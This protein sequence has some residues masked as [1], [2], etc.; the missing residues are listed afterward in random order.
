M[1]LERLNRK[2]LVSEESK[3]YYIRQRKLN[4]WRAGKL[5][6]VQQQ[7]FLPSK[8]P[9]RAEVI[10][11]LVPLKMRV[12]CSGALHDVTVTTCGRIT[13]HSHTKQ[14]LGA[15]RTLRALGD[16]TCGCLDLIKRVREGQFWRGKNSVITKTTQRTRAM[17]NEVQVSLRP[18]PQHEDRSKE[19]RL[20]RVTFRIVREA[21][22]LLQRQ[23][24]EDVQS[25]ARRFGIADANHPAGVYIRV[26]QRWDEFKGWRERGAAE[27]LVVL[28]LDWIL[29]LAD[30][31]Q[32]GVI[33]G[34][35]VFGMRFTSKVHGIATVAV[36]TGL[37]TFE[38]QQ[39]EVQRTAGNP[40]KF[41]S[42]LNEW[43][44]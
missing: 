32:T 19:A 23:Q 41:M 30:R 43:R 1:A 29:R 34:A 21:T 24:Y 35:F 14:D 8:H 27:L 7:E 42:P 37:T 6:P 31:P 36:R 33:E 16:E 11:A 9:I 26:P 4:L 15:L 20:R 22:R 39:R 44:P 10:P 12:R 40:W 17:R 5:P 3:R 28:P 2:A 25:D 38:M 18:E 13:F